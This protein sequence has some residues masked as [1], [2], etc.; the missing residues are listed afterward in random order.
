M[1]RLPI[2]YEQAQSTQLQMRVRSL[3]G[4]AQRKSRQA[5]EKTRKNLN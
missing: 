1:E 4:M 2:Q 5:L 3:R